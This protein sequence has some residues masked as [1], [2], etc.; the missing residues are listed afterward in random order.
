MKDNSWF[1]ERTK[2]WM[3][4]ITMAILVGGVFYGYWA[5]HNWRIE[6][7]EHKIEM[8]LQEKNNGLE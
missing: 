3:V 2:T 7:E 4:I 1:S 6:R 5:A 8:E